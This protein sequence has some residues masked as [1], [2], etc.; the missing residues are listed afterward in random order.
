VPLDQLEI[1]TCLR[2]GEIEIATVFAPD[3][4]AV[5]RDFADGVRAR[6][7][8]TL[9]S[10]DG[11]TVDD[12]V[13]AGLARRTIAV[14]ES[15]TGGLLQSRLTDIPGSS[16]W[17]AGGV[18]AYSN[19]A[20]VLFA[21]VP[22]GLIEHHGAVS[23][24][25]ASALADGIRARLESNIGVGITGVAGPSG[26]SAAKPVGTVAIA[27]AGPEDS[28]L[29]RTVRLYGGRTQIKFSA[30]QAALDMVRR[31]LLAQ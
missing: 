17:V 31:R 10:E 15:C 13:A 12:Q 2:R 4:E 30:T 29:V 23:E 1:T 24:P 22:P 3:A 20:K 7:G 16:A 5:Y 27:I 6:H 11:A 14:A 28:R 8:D 9:F 25:V 26:G 21:G 19:A 18:V